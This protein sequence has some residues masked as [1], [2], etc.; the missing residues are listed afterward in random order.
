MGRASVRPNKNQFQLARESLG[1]TREKA[2]AML[3]TISP[4]RLLKIETEKVTPYPEEILTLAKT[5][6]MP[7]LC[8]CYCARFC[9]IGQ[10]YVP[11]VKMKDLSH[12]VLELL[13]SLNR[14]TVKKEQLIEIATDDGITNDEIDDFID[15]QDELGKV[16]LAIES[17]KLWSEKM[18]SSGVIDMEAYLARRENRT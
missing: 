16:S 2:S 11:E 8:N 5:Y 6:Q 10:V 12:I 7:E 4:E 13:A 1:L 18:L 15:I 9:P 14:M 17:L 3:Q